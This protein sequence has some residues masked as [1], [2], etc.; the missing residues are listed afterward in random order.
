MSEFSIA[1]PDFR[2]V[3]ATIVGTAPLVIE[4][5]SKKGELMEKM[6][7]EKPKAKKADRTAR[8]YDEEARLAKYFSE[9]GWEGFSSSGI[10]K[11]MISACKLVGFKM[12]VAKLS[13]FVIADAIDVD[14]FKP[15][16]RIYGDAVTFTDRTRNAT[17]VTDVRSRPLYKDWASVLNIKYDAGQFR[18]RDVINLLSRV[19]EQVGIGAGRPD[20]RESSGC[21]W[22]TFRIVQGEEERE[23]HEKF[24]IG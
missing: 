18:D 2:V 17:G 4:R 21:G 1:P 9:E 12:T 15:I 23:V 3:R 7:Q 19:G 8:V 22:G 24:G 20:S 5:F 16:T 13:I 10:R 11:G 6:A 14:D